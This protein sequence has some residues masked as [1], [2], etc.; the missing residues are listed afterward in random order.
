MDAIRVVLFS[1]LL[2]A[3]L[4]CSFLA[5]RSWWRFT[6][7]FALWRG[8]LTQRGDFPPW[9]S[10]RFADQLAV[11]DRLRGEERERDEAAEANRQRAR[12]ERR[13]AYAYGI[14]FAAFGVLAALV[15]T[16]FRALGE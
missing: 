11:E 5:A 13:N 14:A 1:L 7:S 15:D 12:R 8:Y 10:G 6:G 16:V 4:V 2:G 3:M 9:P